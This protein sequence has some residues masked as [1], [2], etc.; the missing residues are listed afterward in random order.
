MSNPLLQ[1]F[2]HPP[3]EQ[4]ENKHYKPAI[5]QALNAAR[6]EVEN[7]ST[8][9]EPA[10]FKNT[11]E[12]L[13][14]SGFQLDR[15]VS[16]FFNLNS[17]ET[18]PELQQIAQEISPWL[19]EFNNDI[20]LNKALFSKIKTV[21]EQQ[22]QE[23]L[24]PEQTRLLEKVYKN[25]TRNGA[26]LNEKQQQRLRE[27]DTQLA[28]LSL[29][30]GENVLAETNNFKLHITD[31]SKVEGIPKTVLE[32]AAELA[33]KEDKKEGYL[34]TLD[35]PSFIPVMKYAKHREL[36][37][38]LLKGFGSKA[39]KDND[40]N[41]ESQ[42]LQISKLRFER[43]QLLGYNTHAD[44]VL[45]ERM[46]KSPETVNNF[47]NE[48]LE[49]AKPAAEREFNQ[50]KDF[51]EKTD[52]ITDFQKWD[53]AYYTE[54][55]KSKTFSLKEEDLKPY[56]ELNQVI[57]GLF[58]ITTKLYGLE[59]NENKSYELYH[60]DVKTFDVLENG[61]PK[62]TLYADFHPRAGKRDGAWMTTYKPQF[63]KDGQNE[64]PLVSIVCNFTKPTQSQPSLLT[65]NEVT[66]LFH[67]FGHALHAMLANT[68]YPSLSGANVYWDFV[69]LPSQL[70]ENWCYEPEALQLFAK[71]HKTSEV[72]PE[73]LIAKI[74]AS[75]NFMEG[76]QS[77]RQLSFGQLDLAWHG[78]DP[79]DVNDVKA[80]ELN[81]F[82][83]TALLPDIS[84]NC[85]STAFGHIFQG[86]YSSGYYSYKWAEVLDA[87]AF[88]AFKEHGIFNQT[89][90]DKFKSTVLSKGGTVEPMKLYKSFRGQEPKP[91]ALLKRAG[92]ID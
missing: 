29:K 11:I 46:A 87:D 68:T 1:S 22:N 52:G 8:S 25:F 14:F 69:E 33:Q 58:K 61:S 24:N 85:M 92:L 13:E 30:F 91:D 21:Y 43:A 74:K 79:T 32:S 27:I 84:T 76:L 40:Y 15:I 82:K 47:I 55:L 88:E 71:H 6:E 28:Q 67:E 39:F 41:N 65:F 57:D 90:A 77:L 20:L 12:A 78:I 64:R 56:F 26:N 16:V 72:I 7:I 50:L 38:Q 35:Y 45:E 9:T 51:A 3:F 34:F 54:L 62:A 2:N 63:I 23:N 19:S 31:E 4:I 17:A 53:Q 89:I 59:F 5:E 73:E 36:R 80:H 44:F 75:A 49:K 60:P 10:N 18:N 42:V 81:A 83:P 66:T 48:L 70:L 86:G 37:K